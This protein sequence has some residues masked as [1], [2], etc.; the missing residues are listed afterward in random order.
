MHTKIC[1]CK[2]TFDIAYF[3]FKKKKKT[4]DTAFME[5]G[6]GYGMGFTVYLVVRHGF[7]RGVWWLGLCCQRELW[8]WQWGE[9]EKNNNHFIIL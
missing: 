9:K 7:W 6:C 3:S 4:F 1:F 5:V 2:S 8:F